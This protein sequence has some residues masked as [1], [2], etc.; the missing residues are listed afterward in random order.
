MA[1]TVSAQDV[2]DAEDFLVEFVSDNIPNGDYS[3]GS[4]IRDMAI[5]AVSFIVAYL[6][7]TDEQIRVRQSL[8]TIDEVDTSDDEE[9]AN[10]A[11]DA[12]VA[13]WFASRNQGQFA[14]VTA[15]GFATERID[16]TIGAEILF[17]KTAGL[18]F[19]L[20]NQGADLHVP[21]EDLVAQFDSS[22]VV[23]SYVFRI[24]L[25]SQLTGV[26][27][28][29]NPGRFVSFD[30]FSPYVTHVETLE[31]TTQGEDIENTTALIER[32]RTLITVR[33]LINARSCDAVLRDEFEAVRSLTVIGMGD[34]E[35]VRDRV[36]EAATGLTLHTGGHQDVFID[37]STLETS[38]SGVVGAKF[39]RPDGVISVFRDSTYADYDAT[40]NPTGHKFTSPDP[41]TSLSLE[42][43]MALRIWTGLPLSARDFIIR[44]VRD[45]E[46]YVSE[47]VPFPIATDED[48]TYVTWSVGQNMPN[49]QDV[50]PQTATGQTSQQVQ[51]SGRITLP[52]GPLYNILD[53]TVDDDS[54]PD[55]DPTDG[56]VHLNVRTNEAPTTQVAPDNEYQVVVHTPEA[57]QSNRSYVELLVGPE[58]N[59]AKYDGKTVKVT[60]DTVVGFD[61]VDLKVSN[62]RDR[63]ASASPLTRAYHPVYLSF[64]MEYRL[65]N[66]ATDEIDD[67]A[68]IDELIGYISTFPPTEVIDVSLL[69][70]FLRQVYP[71][72]G[73]VFPFQISYYVHV[74]DGRVVEFESSEAVTV[75][76]AVAEL[77][78][79]LTDPDSA[80][81]GLLNPLDYGVSDDTLRYLA[82][83]DA[84][85]VAKRA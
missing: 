70:D 37:S 22:G 50:V 85:V 76:A 8:K 61:S 78:A 59:L 46:L 21:S 14:R 77:Q 82:L 65:L 41:T 66:S 31:K 69:S 4:L 68:A 23:M 53:V 17:Y 36:V 29:T 73:H 42:A 48:S 52:G 34:N 5:K 33:N 38:F 80:T 55:S 9:A 74:P 30:S 13:N 2:A 40:S 57:H 47:K 32:S 35:M 11:A 81:E 10:D 60:Y 67:N 64:F 25:V 16:I 1:I 15:Y 44:E 49:Y 56:L 20:D 27:Y 84:I 71:Q 3:D 28:N 7:K 6:K 45:T 83:K 79:L 26:A 12:L 54:D 63:I 39:S 18:P 58:G 43:G 51:N 62:R 19:V 72:V 24:P 75:P